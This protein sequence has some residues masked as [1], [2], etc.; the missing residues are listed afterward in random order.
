MKQGYF[1]G[2]VAIESGNKSTMQER[3]KLPGMRWEVQSAQYVLAAK[4]KY[5]SGL[6]DSYVV[7]LIYRHFGLKS[8]Y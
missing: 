3:L 2:N 7:P 4:M 5:D 8:P 1:I 6:W